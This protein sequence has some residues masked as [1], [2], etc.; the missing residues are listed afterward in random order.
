M[1][2]QS[3]LVRKLEDVIRGRIGTSF[4]VESVSQRTEGP[5]GKAILVGGGKRLFVKFSG[6]GAADR[7]EA[8]ADG[9][10]ALRM[11]D[12]LHVPEA[13]DCNSDDEHAW[14][15]LEHLELRP[16]RTVEE[17]RLAAEALTRLHANQSEAFGWHR[18]NHIGDTPQENRQSGN[19]SRFFALQ[20][21]KP[22]FE[23][24]AINGFGAELTKLGQKII[25][26]TPAMFLDYHAR[27]S[28]VHGDL[29]HGNIAISCEKEIVAMYD[30]AVHYGDHEVDLAM[31]E[32]FGGLPN[33]F[34]STYRALSPLAEGHAERKTLYNLYHILNHLNL[35][36]RSYLGQATRMVKDL[37][38]SLGN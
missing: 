1:N 9:L 27:P 19:W 14:I 36:G 35:F 38:L 4:R 17:G 28:L 31:A 26:R 22:Q 32:L 30:P 3:D 21:L 13:I 5:S 23:L 8:E 29:W 34:Y 7:F 24:A 33:T 16:V 37:S 2:G 20:R 12:C 15:V 6:A 25:D 18:D 11:A 10:Q